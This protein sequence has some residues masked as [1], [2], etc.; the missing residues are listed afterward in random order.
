MNYFSEL[1]G[2][3]KYRLKYKVVRYDTFEVEASSLE[4]AKSIATND[5]EDIHLVAS[6]EEERS[7]VK[8]TIIEPEEPEEPVWWDGYTSQELE[9][10]YRS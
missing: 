8:D 6:F 10:I 4:E 2:V 1:N 5:L 3:K 7:L 9:A